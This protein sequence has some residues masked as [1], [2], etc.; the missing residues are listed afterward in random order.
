MLRALLALCFAA[1]AFRV[2]AAI[3]GGP[4]PHPGPALR[5]APAPTL[6]ARTIRQQLAADLSIVRHREPARPNGT[7]AAR[8]VA[9][10]APDGLTLLFSSSSI[11]PRRRTSTR[12]SARHADR[13]RASQPPAILDGLLMLVDA[14]TPI[15]ACREFIAF[16]KLNRVLYGSPASAMCCIWPRGFAQKAGIAIRTCLQGL[17]GGDEPRC[18]SAA[19]R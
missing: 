7:I 11:A 14:K 17:V 3:S 12:A 6:Q 2:G 10:A 16:A 4:G 5:P 8:T 13:L 18:W 15:K 9:T 19:C 1:V